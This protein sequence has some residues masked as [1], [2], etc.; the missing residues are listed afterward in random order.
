[1]ECH[2]KYLTHS[3]RNNWVFFCDCPEY[4]SRVRRKNILSFPMVQEIMLAYALG[5]YTLNIKICLESN[6]RV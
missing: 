5:V 4:M 2:S 6:R 1:M 3:W